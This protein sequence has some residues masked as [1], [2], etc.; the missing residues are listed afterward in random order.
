MTVQIIGVGDEIAMLRGTRQFDGE[1]DRPVIRN[2]GKLQ[3]RHGR[4]SF[5][6]VRA[7]DRD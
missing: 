6:R 4:P 1:L 5:G 2:G 3:L 7:R